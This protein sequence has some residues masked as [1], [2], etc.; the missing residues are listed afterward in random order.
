VRSPDFQTWAPFVQHDVMT[1]VIRQS[2]ESARGV[3]MMK[4]PEIVRQATA[5]KI[6]KVRGVPAQ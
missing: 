3:I 2:R 1:E 4:H 5:A 6:A